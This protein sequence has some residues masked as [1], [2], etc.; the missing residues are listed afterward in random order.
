MML[1]IY[2]SL[3]APLMALCL[4]LV[5]L[6]SR[7]V[8]R[9]LKLRMRRKTWPK[10]G[11]NPIWIHAASGEFEYAKPVIRQLKLSAPDIPIVV[12]YFSPTFSLSVE[13]FPGVDFALPLPLDLPGPCASFLKHIQPRLL[14]IARTD[15]WPEILT[16]TRIRKVPI[17]LFS[18]TQK[19]LTRFGR[20]FAK[21]RL[22][23]VDQVDC[24]SDEDLNLLLELGV[25]PTLDTL[26]DT[27]YDQVH[28]R[29]AH[30]KALPEILKPKSICLVAGS[31]WPED[32]KVLF[33]ALQPLLVAEQLKLILVPHEPTPAHIES[34]R[35]DLRL[36]G[37]KYAL[38]SDERDWEDKAVL[39]VDKVGV[40]A[41]LYLWGNLAFVGGSY[42]S[43]VHSVMEPLGAGAVTFVGPKNQNNREAQEFKALTVMGR[44]ALIE[45]KDAESLQLEIEKALELDHKS[46]RAQ[47]IKAFDLKRGASARLVAKEIGPLR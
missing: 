4:P 14:L 19:P 29:L 44:K 21:F 9:G 28:H 8:R 11:Q 12:T 41:E 30:P 42:R 22:S 24:V 26:G 37:L 1:F 33:T 13:N 2:R 18:Y 47:L 15:I 35:A 7:K 10:F 38:F 17:H 20:T 5:A 6:F 43:T 36:N 31:T 40:L 27:R 45:A 32:E 34:L 25:G 16:Q 46:Y 39:L 23:F 3:V